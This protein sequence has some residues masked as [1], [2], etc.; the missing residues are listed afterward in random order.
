MLLKQIC[1]LHMFKCIR[2]PLSGVEYDM[3]LS[4]RVCEAL[5]Y[6]FRNMLETRGCF[7]YEDLDS[8]F[9]IA[10]TLTRFFNIIMNLESNKK[11]LN[12]DPVCKAVNL[13]FNSDSIQNNLSNLWDRCCCLTHVAGPIDHSTDD[14]IFSVIGWDVYDVVIIDTLTVHLV[15]SASLIQWEKDTLLV[16]TYTNQQ[17]YDS[18][19]SATRNSDRSEVFLYGEYKISHPK[20]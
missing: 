14:D 13:L 7:V 5:D 6:D 15:E 2:L 16:P 12:L 18:I 4:K 11:T 8:C 20:K 1:N 10:T 19:V 3:I 17:G 9:R